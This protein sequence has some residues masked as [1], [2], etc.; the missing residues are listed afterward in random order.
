M[1][2]VAIFLVMG[3]PLTLFVVAAISAASLA[4]AVAVMVERA[5]L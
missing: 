2:S 4:S 3:V 5:A 1:R